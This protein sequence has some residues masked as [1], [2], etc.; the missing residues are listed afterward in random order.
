M[1][2]DGGSV[3]VRRACSSE[4]DKERE[5]L[6]DIKLPKK[7]KKGEMCMT[8]TLS[9]EDRFSECLLLFDEEK[10]QYTLH[11]L[12][13]VVRRI[14]PVRHSTSSSQI[15]KGTESKKTKKTSDLKKRT[16]SIPK[17]QVKKTPITQVK[18]TPITQAKKTPIT[19]STKKSDGLPLPSTKI[20]VQQTN[21]KRAGSKSAQRYELY[22]NAKTL[23]E[24]YSLGGTKGDARND[25]KKKYITIISE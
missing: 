6:V 18:K 2:S 19:S 11:P 16:P 12:S 7:D 25:L 14:A 8:G 17:T 1:K 10:S 9:T 5:R 24:L 3:T 13:G 20:S 15:T 4:E 22:K 21:P 23:S